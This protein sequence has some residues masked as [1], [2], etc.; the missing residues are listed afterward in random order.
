MVELAWW[1]VAGEACKGSLDVGRTWLHVLVCVYFLTRG[2]GSGKLGSSATR[3]G[4]FEEVT[5]EGE[6]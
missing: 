6:E 1:L 5:L 2:L 4:K 3:A